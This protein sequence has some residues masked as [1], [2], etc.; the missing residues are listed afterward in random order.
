MKQVV[1]HIGAPKTGT[2]SL[3]KELARNRSQLG[4]SGTAF[5][6][7]PDT[8][9]ECHCWFAL[10]FV[11]NFNDYLPARRQLSR[12]T[13]YSRLESTGNI[14]R[15]TVAQELKQH[16]RLIISAEQ[17]FSLNTES[18]SLMQQIAESLKTHTT[19]SGYKPTQEQLD[20]ITNF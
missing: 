4:K 1:L 15:A 19:N 6:Q 12:G 9:S 7:L 17:F 2:T 20:E 18:N 14:S 13:S 16:S 3:Q 10:T 8:V 5:H 11:D